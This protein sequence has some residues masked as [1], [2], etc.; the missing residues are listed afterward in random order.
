[1][2]LYSLQMPML[3]S[4]KVN[5][6]RVGVVPWVD[7]V[8]VDGVVVEV[9]EYEVAPKPFLDLVSDDR[10]GM[11]LAL[12]CGGGGVC[13]FVVF[14][15]A[16]FESRVVLPSGSRFIKFFGLGSVTDEIFSAEEPLCQLLSHFCPL[17][18]IDKPAKIIHR[19]LPRI[20][21]NFQAVFVSLTW[22]STTLSTTFNLTRTKIHTIVTNSCLILKSV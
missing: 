4:E 18:L 15:L 19:A 22:H 10:V 12:V 20:N 9:V 16:L 11:V 2:L 21:T 13:P 5:F 6:D 14:I 17:S 1:M 3:S 7:A 8:V